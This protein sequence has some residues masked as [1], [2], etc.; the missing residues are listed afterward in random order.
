MKEEKAKKL[1]QDLDARV[2]IG[3]KGI[4]DGIVDEINRHLENEE[5]VKI[6]V[7]RNNPILDIDKTADM[8]EERTIGEVV[9]KRGKTVL[10]LYEE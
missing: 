7:L 9:E 6:K 1:G 5:L 8:L 10:M 2:R 4:T 3:K